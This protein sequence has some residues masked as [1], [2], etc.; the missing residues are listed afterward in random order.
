MRIPTLLLALLCIPFSSCE[1]SPKYK[2][3]GDDPTWIS[4]EETRRVGERLITNRYPRAQLVE[5]LGMG[6]TFAY[7]FATN[8]TV[9]PMSVVVDRKTGKAKFES[10]SQ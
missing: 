1:R 4:A 9:L 8:G 10:S 2:L 3:G 6:R 7:R 5:E